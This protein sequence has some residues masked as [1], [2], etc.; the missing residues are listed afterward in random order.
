M[1]TGVKAIGRGLNHSFIIMAVGSEVRG[2]A[3]NGEVI[4]LAWGL[5]SYVAEG[6]LPP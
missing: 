3:S 2:R 5:A 1:A 4:F 6:W